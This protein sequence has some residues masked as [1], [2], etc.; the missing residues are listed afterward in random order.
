MSDVT[1]IRYANT[2]T[3]SLRQLDELNRVSKG[4]TFRLFKRREAELT[5]GVDYF[6]LSGETHD[7]MI[8]SLKQ[9]RQIYASTVHLILLT[10][11]GYERLRAG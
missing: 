9:S 3:L 5:E 6:Y 11:S 10:R 2:E 1:P 7:E 8:E 4:T